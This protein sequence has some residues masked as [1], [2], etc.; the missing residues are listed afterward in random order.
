MIETEDLVAGL[1]TLA[2]G[3]RTTRY[4]RAQHFP[5]LVA[6]YRRSPAE[7][8]RLWHAAHFLGVDRFSPE[9]S[10]TAFAHAHGAPIACLSPVDD[11]KTR[12]KAF[13]KDQHGKTRTETIPTSQR[14]AL[15][16]ARCHAQLPNFWFR[17]QKREV[18]LP[19]EPALRFVELLANIFK[20]VSLDTFAAAASKRVLVEKRQTGKAVAEFGPDG[21][22]VVQLKDLQQVDK[23]LK[24]NKIAKRRQP[25][26]DEELSD[27][28]PGVDEVADT[29]AAIH[30]SESDVGV[31]IAGQSSSTPSAVD[32]VAPHLRL[33]KRRRVEETPSVDDLLDDASQPTPCPTPELARGCNGPQ[34]PVRDTT[35]YGNDFDESL[36]VNS[37]LDDSITGG[38]NNTPRRCS[39]ELFR[40]GFQ[41]TSGLQNPT[42]TSPS[43]T[44]WLDVTMEDLERLPADQRELCMGYKQ[45]YN[46][47]ETTVK[48]GEAE[49]A[50]AKLCL[51][52]SKKTCSLLEIQQLERL[53]RD[54]A[55]KPGLT[56]ET[57]IDKKKKAI[58]LAK[59][60]REKWQVLFPELQE[61]AEMH[62][63]APTS[64]PPAIPDVDEMTRELKDL[65]EH[66]SALA[67]AKLVLEKIETQV[68][69]MERAVNTVKRVKTCPFR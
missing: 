5:Q 28:E 32:K 58:E 31:H 61:L 39:L 56:L 1:R 49:V 63:A 13:Y 37:P 42:P 59:S 43:A 7:L 47:L 33:R 15:A 68:E 66:Q 10:F 54:R 3:P 11:G 52:N 50:T 12:R 8:L 29:P 67:K 4:S 44:F 53:Q 46:R 35:S 25:D 65:E 55:F 41:R 34:T 17:L 2:H 22:R 51:E 45:Y 19:V 30:V 38:F 21:T 62:N 23:L 18:H 24:R 36:F 40:P 60:A 69:E 64:T 26:E 6:A 48:K 14:L 57:L 9:A 27:V 20:N 16:I